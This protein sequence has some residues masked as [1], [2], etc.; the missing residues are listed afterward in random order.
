[1]RDPISDLFLRIKNG[2]SRK[3]EI[4]DMPSSRLAADV[5]RILFDEGFISK[6]EMLA[7]GGKKILRVTLKYGLDKYGKPSRSLISELKQISKPGRRIYS[8]NRQR[9]RVSNPGSASRS[10]RRLKGS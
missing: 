1:M 4:V 10:C 6:Y 5:S 8:H 7:R 2:I 9:S 3:K